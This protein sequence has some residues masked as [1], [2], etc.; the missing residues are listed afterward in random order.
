MNKLLKIQEE[1]KPIE[2][3]AVNPFFKSRYFDINTMLAE[4]KP[5]LQKYNVI[6]L[7]PMDVV[8]GRTILR[9]I[10]L[11]AEDDSGKVIIAGAMALPVIDDPQKMGSAITY[12]RRYSLQSLFALEAVDDD[13]EGVLRPKYDYVNKKD[14]GPDQFGYKPKKE[15]KH[16]D[17][18]ID[19]AEHD[20]AQEINL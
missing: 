12:F 11:D 6:L 10:L 15:P 9:T 2:K 16:K 4:I 5:I 7:Q 1:L 20:T 13:A 17:V 3:D 19:S 18:A 8:E 14:L